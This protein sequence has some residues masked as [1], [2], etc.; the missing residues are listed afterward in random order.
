MSAGS[1]GHLIAGKALV[2]QPA[3]ASVRE[4][5]RVMTE[6]G[7]GA[8]PV[9]EG[10]HLI[11]IFTERDVLVRVVASSRDADRTRLGEV[12]TRR[13]ET[14][15][16]SCSLEQA[17]NVMVEGGFRHLPVVSRGELVGIISLR[18]IP[19]EMQARRRPVR[20]HDQARV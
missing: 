7:I 20:E 15:S 3:T 5:A 19:I 12:M 10:R 11:G 17:L 8:L 9:V 14:V 4:A 2:A 16:L 13:P 1:V 6:H 18:D